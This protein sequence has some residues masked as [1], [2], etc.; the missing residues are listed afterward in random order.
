[1]RFGDGQARLRHVL[2]GEFLEVGG[3]LVGGSPVSQR[4]GHPAGG[5]DGQGQ[6]HVAVGKRLGHQCVGDGGALL[7]DTVE[8]LGHR[9]RG[10]AEFGG[11]GDQVGRV[12][13]GVVGVAGG[14]PQDLLGELLHRLDDHPL[15]VVGGQIEVVGRARCQARRRLAQSLDLLELPGRGSGGREAV[16]DAELQR[17]VERV[18]QF[19]P[20]QEFL[21]Q[22]RGEQA[23]AEVDRCP[24]AA[25]LA[26]GAVP[27]TRAGFG[28]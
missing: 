1:M 10:D 15:V 9:E 2:P 14:G 22:Q 13:G 18:A 28:R 25:E 11:P 26:D 8:V 7:G 21:A 20:V 12:G 5:Q 16:L 17:P 27:R 3:L 23:H 6:A 24:L 4:G 19:V